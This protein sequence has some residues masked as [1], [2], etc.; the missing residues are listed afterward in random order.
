[1]QAFCVAMMAVAVLI[2]VYLYGKGG[3]NEPRRLAGA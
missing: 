2:I 1:M 3:G